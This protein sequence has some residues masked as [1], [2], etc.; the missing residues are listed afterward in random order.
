MRSFSESIGG[1]ARAMDFHSS[2]H[3]L[4]SLLVQTNNDD[5]GD[6][7]DDDGGEKKE[8]HGLGKFPQLLS[9]FLTSYWI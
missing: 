5:D 2:T 1:C 6:D 7:D 4:A 9:I 3:V 8:A